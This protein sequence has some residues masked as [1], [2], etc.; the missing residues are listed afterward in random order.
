MKLLTLLPFLF[1]LILFISPV[2]AYYDVNATEDTMLDQFN[3]STSYGAEVSITIGTLINNNWRGLYAFNLSS[4]PYDESITSSN[5]SLK[6]AGFNNATEILFV[7]FNTTQFFEANATWNNQPDVDTLQDNLSVG[8]AMLTNFSVLEATKTAHQQN[9]TLYLLIRADQENTSTRNSRTWYS[10][11]QPTYEPTLRIETES[12]GGCSGYTNGSWCDDYNL[13]LSCTYTQGIQPCYDVYTENPNPYN[14]SLR[15]FTTYDDTEPDCILSINSC[16]VG[17]MC[18]QYW[19]PV[20]HEYEGKVECYNGQDGSAYY[21]NETGDQFNG[22]EYTLGLT[23][24]ACDDPSIFTDAWSCIVGYCY[25]CVKYDVCVAKEA[26]CSYLVNTTCTNTSTTCYDK[27]CNYIMCSNDAVQ[28]LKAWTN[29]SMGTQFGADILA[30]IIATMFGI[31]AFM[32]T[33]MKEINAL[34]VVFLIVAGAEAFIGF[35][36]PWFLM[37]E[38][39]AVGVLLF[40][41]V[42]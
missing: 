13:T 24:D 10:S 11:E 28:Q 16:P 4:V 33:K 17:Y 34:L 32:A 39:V 22:T 6:Y 2:L 25:W 35:L 21:Y 37:L 38:A 14:D 40:F 8:V 36:T 23:T 41:K 26:D 3:P 9:T 19:N 20:S 29:A 15:T 5:I 30:L 12:G 42:G 31:G 27:N 18:V 7:V 1:F